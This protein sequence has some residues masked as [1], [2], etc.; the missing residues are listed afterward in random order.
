MTEESFKMLVWVD[1]ETQSKAYKC[2]LD[3]SCLNELVPP[4][5]SDYFIRNPLFTLTRQDKATTFIYRKT[6]RFQ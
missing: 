2:V 6:F 4:Y 3:F 1:L 5:L